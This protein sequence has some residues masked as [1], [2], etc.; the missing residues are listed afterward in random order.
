M[1]KKKSAPKTGLPEERL[2]ISEAPENALQ[3]LFKPKPQTY[4]PPPKTRR[5]KKP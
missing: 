5:K 1:P 3:K 2:V 4:P